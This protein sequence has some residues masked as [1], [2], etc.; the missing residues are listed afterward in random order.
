MNK[1][2]VSVTGIVGVLSVFYI[3]SLS[4]VAV[5]AFSILHLS[6][7]ID[8]LLLHLFNHLL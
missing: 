8:G 5:F 1:G 4:A 3:P 7:R 6:N 2:F